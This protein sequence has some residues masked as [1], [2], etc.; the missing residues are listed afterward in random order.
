ME[1]T[2]QCQHTYTT[3]LKTNLNYNK[4]TKAAEQQLGLIQTQD[5]F[6]MAVSC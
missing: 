1:K 2:G 3:K 4:E 6:M 5:L